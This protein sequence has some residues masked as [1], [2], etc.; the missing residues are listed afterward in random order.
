LSNKTLLSDYR[1]FPDIYV[2]QGSVTTR[3]RCGGIFDDH[4]IGSF[5]LS[6]PAKSRSTFG[7]VMGK[8][9]VSC[10][11]NHEG[12]VGVDRPTLQEAG[13][14]GGCLIAQVM[15]YWCPIKHRCSQFSYVVPMLTLC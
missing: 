8:S 1:Q 14:H 9:R 11:F 13:S 15:A 12:G 2:L 10:F 3:L 4:F 6:P 5:L 7:K